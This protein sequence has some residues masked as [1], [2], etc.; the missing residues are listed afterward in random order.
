MR[1]LAIASCV[2][3]TIELAD[4]GLFAFAS[5]LVFPEIF[6]PA[7]GSAAGL[8]ASL[9]TFGVV[10]VARPIGSIVFGHFGDR[11]GRKGTLL[12]T[13]VI[14]GVSTVLVGCI[15]PASQ[16]GVAAPILLVALRFAQGL[17][18]GGE[19]AGAILTT[20]EYA[21]TE[22]RG[23]WAMSASLGGGFGA[24]LSSALIVGGSLGMSDESYL[25][26]GWRLPFLASIVL[27][28]V[29]LWARLT[30]EETPVFRAEVAKHGVTRVPILDAVRAQPR[31]IVLASGMMLMVYASYYLGITFLTNYATSDLGIARSTALLVALVATV[32]Y[33]AG[34]FL[35]GALADRFGRRRLMLTAAVAA[36]VFP[37]VLFLFMRNGSLSGLVVAMCGTMFIT[38]TATGP[39]G[40]FLSELFLTR[41]RY[42]AAGFCYNFAGILGGAVPPLFAASITA[43]YGASMYG[44][45]VSVLSVISLL[46]V[47]GLEEPKG[48]DLSDVGSD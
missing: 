32:F 1:K 31:Q 48:R 33:T 19:W 4:F 5:V 22:R 11:L 37:L 18:V 9:A 12:T 7:L 35:T 34:I 15:P 26:W 2:G 43:S 46:C 42:S 28:G 6:F 47:L 25:S 27:V 40:A 21:P 13:L 20:A 29:G 36:V 16:I 30:I 17:A 44:V 39:L 38:G 14:M 3:T 23:F 10:F 8:T 24:V 45:L 41:Y